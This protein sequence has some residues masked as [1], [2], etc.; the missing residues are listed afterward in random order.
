LAA[1][2]L[3]SAP[4]LAVDLTVG[5]ASVAAGNTA[6]V[7][8][9]VSNM[10]GSRAAPNQINLSFNGTVLTR[11]RPSGRRHARGLELCEQCP[12]RGFLYFPVI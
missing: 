6:A 9:A 10:A 2:L 11:P 1:V 5:T 7:T 12:C 8:V 3:A 4:A